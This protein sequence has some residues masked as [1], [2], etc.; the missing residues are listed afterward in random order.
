MKR[1]ALLLAVAILAGGC[2][3]SRV[4][5]AG[6]EAELTYDGLVPVESA[7][8]ENFWAK[9][10]IDYASY[11]K[12]LLDCPEF[13]FRASSHTRSSI[14]GTVSVPLSLDDQVSF[15]KMVE[16][17]F[18]EELEGNQHFTVVDEP[19]TDVMTLEC[20]ILDIVALVPE[21]RQP[22]EPEEVYFSSAGKMTLVVEAHD[23]TTGEILARAVERRAADI[24]PD[25]IRTSRRNGWAEFKPIARQWAVI[26]RA[27]L[28]QIHELGTIF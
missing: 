26:L 9:P 12:I 4:I 25:G 15:A 20:T 3:S 13:E 19:G 1:S 8:V 7:K 23:S 11:N 27:R 28:D 14:G 24:A 17:I 22:D 16:S 2:P 10:D 5:D 18:R 21:R 6:P